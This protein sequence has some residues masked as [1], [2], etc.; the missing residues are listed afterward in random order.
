MSRHRPDGCT[1]RELKQC[2]RCLRYTAKPEPYLHIIR[3]YIESGVCR[4]QLKQPVALAIA[5]PKPP[6]KLP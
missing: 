6:E 1:G 2:A 4:D 5:N 3:P